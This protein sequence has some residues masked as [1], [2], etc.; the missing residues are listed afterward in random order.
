VCV[1]V[2]VVCV[3]EG[4]YLFGVSD[5][6]GVLEADQVFIQIQ[7]PDDTRRQVITGPVVVARNPCLHAGD[8]RVLT[9]VDHPQLRPFVNVIVFP[10]RGDRPIPNQLSGGDLDGDQFHI[11]WDGRLIPTTPNPPAAECYVP[12]R[13]VGQPAAVPFEGN[14]D[15]RD[16]RRRAQKSYIVRHFLHYNL[17]VFARACLAMPH[18]TEIYAH[19]KALHPHCMRLAE[20][21]SQAVD[22]PKTGVPVRLPE[23]LRPEIIPDFMAKEHHKQRG[24]VFMSDSPIG[25]VTRAVK[26]LDD[27]LDDTHTRAAAAGGGDCDTPFNVQASPRGVKDGQRSIAV[28]WSIPPRMA[29]HVYGHRITCCTSNDAC[30]PSDEWAADTHSPAPKASVSVPIHWGWMQFRVQVVFSDGNRSGPSPPCQPLVIDVDPK[31]TAAQS[32]PHDL[33]HCNTLVVTVPF[34]GLGVN[35]LQGEM[36]TA[37]RAIVRRPPANG[38][39]VSAAWLLTEVCPPSSHSCSWYTAAI[40]LASAALTREVMRVLEVK[41]QESGRPRPE[42]F[43]TYR[44]QQIAVAVSWEEDPWITAYRRCVEGRSTA[45]DKAFPMPEPKTDRI[46][47]VTNIAAELTPCENPQLHNHSRSFVAAFGSLMA[48]LK[49]S[50]SSYVDVLIR[51]PDTHTCCSPIDIIFLTVGDAEGFRAAFEANKNTLSP[52]AE[53]SAPGF[54]EGAGHLEQFFRK[55]RRVEVLNCTADMDELVARLYSFW[56]QTHHL[57]GEIVWIEERPIGGENPLGDSLTR[58]SVTYEMEVSTHAATLACLSSPTLSC[59]STSTTG[60]PIDFFIR[61]PLARLAAAR[62]TL[63]PSYGHIKGEGVGEKAVAT[64]SAVEA[65]T[66]GAIVSMSQ[67]TDTPEETTYN[68]DSEGAAVGSSGVSTIGP[69]DEPETDNDGDAAWV[70]PRDKPLPPAVDWQLVHRDYERHQD[71]MRRHRDMWNHQLSCLMRKYGVAKEAEAC[72]GCVALWQ[73]EPT[74]RERDAATK[75]SV[76]LT[77]LRESMQQQLAAPV[78][79]A[80]AGDDTVVDLRL[81]RASAAYVVTRQDLSVLAQL[82]MGLDDDSETPVRDF[83]SFP[84]MVF[85]EELIRLKNRYTDY[86]KRRGISH[87]P[88]VQPTA[89]PAQAFSPAFFAPSP[90][91]SMGPHVGSREARLMREQLAFVRAAIGSE[92]SA[93]SRGPLTSDE[94]PLSA[95]TDGWFD[96]WEGGERAANGR[97]D[98]QPR[99]E[100]E[101][102]EGE[103]DEYVDDWFPPSPRQVPPPPAGWVAP[104]PPHH[105]HREHPPAV[106]QTEQEQIEE[107]IRRSLEDNHAS[108][109]SSSMCETALRDE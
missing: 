97:P 68:G 43:L 109:L 14:M 67:Q 9:A 65:E 69:E 57:T 88:A 107:A 87:Q 46:L 63:V 33:L 32:L 102:G 75:L 17:G 39:V 70:W 20:L 91:V 83:L 74:A 66:V 86:A 42:V 4:A 6:V 30:G 36:D 3:Q 96:D 49:E 72:M 82:G 62:R 18:Q 90:C 34:S 13:S 48:M 100:D 58:P 98:M 5:E 10:V 81:A 105:H 8:L 41:C 93:F 22:F 2:C 84:W 25:V 15:T 51:P 60:H 108:A 76:E 56:A 73:E 79:S 31:Y 77:I 64:T 38:P 94:E 44:G 54:R 106:P 55:P 99:Q 103:G 40:T 27:S 28:H 61:R 85:P 92:L 12:D 1:C 19:R 24:R 78:T 21:H 16:G 45:A 89:Q 104:T 11:L 7:R 101:Q 29:R 35:L 37:L 80:N 47:R 52:A 95:T 26:A 71:D 53:I 50:N 23:T 59:T